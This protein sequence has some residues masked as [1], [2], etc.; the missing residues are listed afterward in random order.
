MMPR[1]FGRLAPV[2]ALFAMLA[3]GCG[4]SRETHFEEGTIV[5]THTEI[6][7]GWLEGVAQSGQLDS[8]AATMKDEI[9]ALSEEGVTT[10]AELLADYEELSKGGSPAK[11]K[12]KAQEMLTKLPPPETVSRTA[13][14][15]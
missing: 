15:A 9:Q 5:P 14:G 2:L 10:T 1:T 6:V 3:A 12:A 13:E 11:V 4:E 7:R 8:G